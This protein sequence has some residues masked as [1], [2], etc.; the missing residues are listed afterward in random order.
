MTIRPM[1]INTGE[2]TPGIDTLIGP[3]PLHALALHACR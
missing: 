2:T 3:I 1:H